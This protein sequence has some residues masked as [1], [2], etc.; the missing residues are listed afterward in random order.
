MSQENSPVAAD[1]AMST[2][3][4]PP[5]SPPK[6]HRTMRGPR[7]RRDSQRGCLRPQPKSSPQRR[8]D[9]LVRPLRPP[10]IC[11]RKKF[12]SALARNSSFIVYVPRSCLASMRENQPANSRAVNEPVAERAPIKTQ[13]PISSSGTERSAMSRRFSR[14]QKLRW[15]LF[16][17]MDGGGKRRN[18]RWG[19][20]SPVFRVPP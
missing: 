6:G 14:L 9:F 19:P 11:G 5:L 8:R 16:V 2:W 20:H 4:P 3:R 12:F 15:A 10:R 7:R 17:P 1:L 18:L 13:S